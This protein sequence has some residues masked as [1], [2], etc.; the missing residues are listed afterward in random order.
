MT[1]IYEFAPIVGLLFFFFIFLW[2]ALNTYRPDKKK[3]LQS[4]AFIPLKEE[5]NH[6]RP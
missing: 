4:Y 1:L 6:D 3:S 2:I 5:A